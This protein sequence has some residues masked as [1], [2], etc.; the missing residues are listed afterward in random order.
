MAYFK[1]LSFQ[2]YPALQTWVEDLIGTTSG[3]TG[4]T[5][6]TGPTGTLGNTGATGAIGTPGNTGATGLP[7][8]ATNTGAT[9]PIGYQ[10][11]T[12]ATG[13]TGSIGATGPTGII[14]ST[15]MTGATG[16]PGSATNTGATGPTGIIGPTGVTGATGLPGSATNTGATGPTGT[17]FTISSFTGTLS[18]AQIS[19]GT[20]ITITYS[21]ANPMAII[22]IPNYQVVNFGSTSIS[23]S[24]IPSILVP[25]TNGVSAFGGSYNNSETVAYINEYKI[26]SSDNVIH[27]T[28]NW[29]SFAT[30]Y[31]SPLNFDGISLSYLTS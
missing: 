17:H 2:N 19:P 10:G 31:E 3:S 6:P 9:G 20:T 27:I 22:Y 18:G 16:L 24:G 26:N 25:N 4:S 12:G 5:G 13:N 15:G 11:N 1:Q 29:P 7:G 30:V 23:I 14:G 21:Y 8:L 28:L